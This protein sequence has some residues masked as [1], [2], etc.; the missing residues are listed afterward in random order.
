MDFGREFQIGFSK[1]ADSLPITNFRVELNK[2]CM[3]SLTSS[4]STNEFEDTHFF[5]EIKYQGNLLYNCLKHT[6]SESKFDEMR[7]GLNNI[8]LDGLTN[9]LSENR[10]N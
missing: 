6:K 3:S 7:D 1:N 2:P 4:W 5:N 9:I 8:M 10:G